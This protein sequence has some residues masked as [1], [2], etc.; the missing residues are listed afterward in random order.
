LAIADEAKKLKVPFVG[1]VPNPPG[2]EACANAGQKSFE[3]MAG[4]KRYLQQVTGVAPDK[5]SA[6]SFSTS[7]T[8]ALCAI[9]LRNQA[10]LCPTL[11]A[12]F[13]LAG[14]PS[15]G[16][17][18][19]LRYFDDPT[20]AGWAVWLKNPN[21]AAGRQSYQLNLELVG[22]MHKAGVGILAGTDTN[23]VPA[24]TGNAPYC[25]PGFGLHDELHHL[26]TAGL[27]TMDA[28]RTATYNPAMFLGLLDSLGTVEAGKL[29]ELVLLDA[30]PL[31]DIANTRK[32]NMVFTGGRLYR[33]PA[34][35]SMLSAVETNIKNA[36][37]PSNDVLSKYVGIYEF[38]AKELGIPGPEK[39]LVNV[40]LE[41][42]VL[43]LGIGDNPRQPLTA[44]SETTFTGFGD[45]VEFAKNGNSEVPELLIRFGG[46]DL[47]ADKKN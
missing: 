8:E 38:N 15:L 22:A 25:L 40:V 41:E 16:R 46:R 37:R 43:W 5:M 27:S 1:H 29:A 45:R 9:F 3:H 35:D 4:V 39:Q 28:L 13:G 23:M 44:I 33:R 17:D 11:T 2:L 14:D 31:D 18:P 42:A 32:I 7:Q 26:V 12:A 10:W 24:S 20:R 19:R 6:T 47:R 36:F 30:N 34:L 21:L